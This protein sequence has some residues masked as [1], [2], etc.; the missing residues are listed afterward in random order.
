V[1]VVEL[2]LPA[3]VVDDVELDASDVLGV[4]VE[5][6]VVPDASVGVVV[7]AAGSC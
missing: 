4:G 6:A 3:A 2:V 5:V 7:W 1:L